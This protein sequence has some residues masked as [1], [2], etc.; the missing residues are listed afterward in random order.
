MEGGP[1]PIVLG[2]LF[3][4]GSTNPR[5]GLLAKFTTLGYSRFRTGVNPHLG[6][7]LVNTRPKTRQC[8]EVKPAQL[9]I[10]LAI[11]TYS[12]SL[13]LSQGAVENNGEDRNR[14]RVP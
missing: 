14:T 6:P 10:K 3:F 12:P 5:N 8:G 2:Y 4:E 11:S 1:V 7:K 13:P 9:R